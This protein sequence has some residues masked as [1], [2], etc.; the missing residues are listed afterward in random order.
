MNIVFNSANGAPLSSFAVLRR[1]A[2]GY[3]A[4]AA[5]DDSKTKR[6]SN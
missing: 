6:R 2:F 3:A 4:S 5:Q 1:F